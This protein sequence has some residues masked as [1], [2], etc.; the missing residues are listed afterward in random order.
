MAVKCNATLSGTYYDLLSSGYITAI[1][2]GCT[3]TLG[4]YFIR[5]SDGFVEEI[6]IAPYPYCNYHIQDLD[7]KTNHIGLNILR[8]VISDVRNLFQTA[9]CNEIQKLGTN[10]TEMI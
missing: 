4:M 5:D 3:F 7:I 2:T 10:L 1:A 8:P 6:K 9:I